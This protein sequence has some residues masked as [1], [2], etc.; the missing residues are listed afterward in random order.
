MN[1]LVPQ[2]NYCSNTEQ[3]LRRLARN[4]SILLRKHRTWLDTF[5]QFNGRSYGANLLNYPS[6]KDISRLDL[7]YLLDALA[8]S[9]RYTQ[10]TRF[11]LPGECKLWYSQLR[12]SVEEAPAEDKEWIGYLKL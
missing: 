3:N 9:F 5:M 1:S 10:R 11:E 7:I 6:F 4:G 8:Y 12:T 2:A